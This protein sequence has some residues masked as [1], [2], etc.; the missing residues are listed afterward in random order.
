M[1]EAIKETEC[2]QP[3][4][5]AFGDVFI[6][7]NET[8]YVILDVGTGR[9][10]DAAQIINQNSCLVIGI[11]GTTMR[12]NIEAII[13]HWSLEEILAAT[14]KYMGDEKPKGEFYDCIRKSARKEPRI[15]Q[16]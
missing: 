9:T 11:A 14:M 15:L 13:D 16:A 7:K 1:K 3:L 5:I 6:T 10:C 4:R 2:L 12:Q 8:E